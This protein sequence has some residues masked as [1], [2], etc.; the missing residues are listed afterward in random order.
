MKLIQIYQR[1]NM[2][3]IRQSPGLQISCLLKDDEKNFTSIYLYIYNIY[4]FLFLF[5]FILT[6]E[7]VVAFYQIG[8]NVVNVIILF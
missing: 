1:L 8:I 2:S 3:L 7:K 4:E 5:S 6:R